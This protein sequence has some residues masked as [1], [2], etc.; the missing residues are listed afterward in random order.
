[1]KPDRDVSIPQAEFIAF[2]RAIRGGDNERVG[3]FNSSSGIHHLQASAIVDAL[4][5]QVGFNSSSG[6]HR[7]Q[8]R[9]GRWLGDGN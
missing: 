2:K 5:T 3:G 7:L 4:Y 9:P 8:A 1:M 6:I